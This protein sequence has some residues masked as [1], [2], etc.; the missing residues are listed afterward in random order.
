MRIVLAPLAGFTDAP[1][2]LMCQRGGAD[3]TYTEMVSAAALAH[4]HRATRHLMELLPSEGPVACQIFGADESEVAFAAEQIGQLKGANGEARRFVA[5]D[6]NA[7]CPMTN[8]T[9]CGAGAKL[10]EAPQRIGRLLR[11][12]RSA[13]D[14]PI[15]L[16]TRL[17]PH[18]QWRTIDEIV[19]EAEAA[20]VASITIHAR[21]TSQLHG[22]EVHY[23]D[24]ADV[25]S[26]AH[27]PIIGNGSVVSRASFQA[28]KS[29]GVAGVM[30]GRA[31]LANPDIFRYLRGEELPEQSGLTLAREHL[32]LVLEFYDQLKSKFPE[33]HLPSRDAFAALH[34]H[35]HIFRYFNGLPGAAAMRAR[36]NQVRDLAGINDEFQQFETLNNKKVQ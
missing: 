2:R 22:G 6:L 7:G 27:V 12:M 8:V 25:V 21:Y 36:L 18:P 11:A 29:T 14:L 1:F 23:A 34:L 4:G 9:R 26:H 13:T 17:G 24:L 3:L 5:L 28:M 30:I 19:G 20:G 15:T 32:R 35:T 16:K 10:V 31:A 33:D